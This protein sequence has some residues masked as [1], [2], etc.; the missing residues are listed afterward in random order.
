[1]CQE[2]L[3]PDV[4]SMWADQ[5]IPALNKIRNGLKPEENEKS[6]E[7]QKPKSVE[8]SRLQEL[9]QA[10]GW[11]GGTIHQILGVLRRAKAVAQAH[12]E[13]EI[14][15]EWEVFK[16]EIYALRREIC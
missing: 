13:A 7:E 16:S 9:L 2:S 1:M 11:Q 4:Y 15:G 10:L 3:S 14:S 5:I 6:T 12:K 8:Y